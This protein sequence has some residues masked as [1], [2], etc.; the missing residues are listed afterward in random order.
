M[1]LPNGYASYKIKVVSLFFI[2]PDR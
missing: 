2:I 1:I